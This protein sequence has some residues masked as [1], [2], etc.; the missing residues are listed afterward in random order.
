MSEGHPRGRLKVM[1]DALTGF[2]QSQWPD[3]SHRALLN[4]KYEID[5]I[6]IFIEL[7]KGGDRWFAWFC[8]PPNMD[9][10]K[11]KSLRSGILEQLGRVAEE[12][13]EAVAIA[14]AKDLKECSTKQGVAILRRWRKGTC[15]PA[16]CLHLT[17]II[18]AAINSYITVH[19]DVTIT[20]VATALENAGD[21]FTEA[22]SEKN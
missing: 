7:W 21:A 8:H 14:W 15:S 11:A 1:G 16:N 3:L 4:K 20:M 10:G 6:R 9:A 18:V 12:R 2:L 13:G 5:A 19:P 17:K 22:A